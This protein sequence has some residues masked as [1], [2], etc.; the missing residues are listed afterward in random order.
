MKADALKLVGAA[1]AG[2]EAL[3]QAFP[4]VRFTSGR[5]KAEDQARAMAQN[6]FKNRHWIAQTYRATAESAALQKWVS[7][8]LEADTVVEIQA[9]LLSIMT[10]WTDAQKRR[11]SKHFSGEAFDVQPVPGA[12][13]QAIKAFIS[14]LPG[15]TLLE[16]EGGLVR[17][18]AQAN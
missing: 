2:A 4:D 18:H 8:H 5:R 10:P 9:G 11:L 16:K 13:G 14:A 7:Q 17:W 3:E 1:K 6:V 12:R 15:L